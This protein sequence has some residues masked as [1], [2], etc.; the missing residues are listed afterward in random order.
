LHKRAAR[1]EREAMRLLPPRGDP[2][3]VGHAGRPPDSIPVREL[4]GDPAVPSALS[5]A[6]IPRILCGW[7]NAAAKARRHN[8]VDRPSPAGISPPSMSTFAAPYVD[9]RDPWRLS[10]PATYLPTLFSAEGWGRR[11]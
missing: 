3:D 10:A 8:R 1:P 4:R 7:S 9:E 5:A 6:G 11:L 2:D